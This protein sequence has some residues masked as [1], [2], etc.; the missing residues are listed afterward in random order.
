M[1]SDVKLGNAINDDVTGLRTAGDSKIYYFAFS[2]MVGG[3][4]NG[5][6]GVADGQKNGKELADFI[7]SLSV[8]S[9]L[10]D[11]YGNNNDFSI[12]PNPVMNTLNFRSAEK[13]N[14]IEISDLDGKMIVSREMKGTSVMDMNGYPKGI[15]ILKATNAKGEQF[16][17]KIVKN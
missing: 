8:A 15:F 11:I 16:V 14:S 5:H 17:R 7:K 10:T 13:V 6:P 9:E 3:G 2:H 4:A 12:F 1:I